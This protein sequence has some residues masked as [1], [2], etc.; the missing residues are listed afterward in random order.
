[1]LPFLCGMVVQSVG[2]VAAV[3]SSGRGAG[4]KDAQPPVA[5]VE[6]APGQDPDIDAEQDLAEEGLLQPDLAGDGS[7]EQAGREDRAEHRRARKGVEDGA[8]K[9]DLCSP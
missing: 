6:A 5:Q 2:M 1:M 9:T 8:N 7:A 4:E 3:R